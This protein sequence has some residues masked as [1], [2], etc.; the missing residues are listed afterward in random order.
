MFDRLLYLPP[1]LL[2]LATGSSVLQLFGRKD[3]G[4]LASLLTGVALWMLACL[5]I[6]NLVVL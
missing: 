4:E 2:F 3:P 6:L 1:E 5:A